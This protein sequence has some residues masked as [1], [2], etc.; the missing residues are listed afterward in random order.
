MALPAMVLCAGLGTR[1]RPLSDLRP[2]ALVPVGDRPMLAHVLDR[3]AA[4]GIERVAVNAHHRA[5][6]L[7]AWLRANAPAVAVSDEPEL[8]GTAGGL[9]HARALLGTGGGALVWNG[10]I[11]ADVDLAALLAAAAAGDDAALAVRPCA[12]GE[13]NV[14]FDAA[15]RVVRLRGERVAA[16]ARG[17][18]FLG[19]H[20]VGARLRDA[21]PAR[22]CLVGDVYIPA[23]RAGA[24][25]RAAAHDG[26]FV[27][28]GSPAGYLAANVAWLAARGLRSW[29]GEAARVAEGVALDGSVVGAGA[30]VEGSGALARVVVWP[31]VRVRAPLADAVATEGGLVEV[32][33][34]LT[35]ATQ[36]A[37]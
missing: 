30:V 29:V 31:G 25:L 6:E 34:A 27:D 8:L 2:K 35:A 15:G 14:G 1:L 11:L 37:R 19:V 4:A 13:G 3:L 24:L 9:A 22:G 36:P 10:D 26:P 17:G 20:V 23:M 21:L 33:P 5:G 12:P 18:E 28:V 16:E 7:R 32:G